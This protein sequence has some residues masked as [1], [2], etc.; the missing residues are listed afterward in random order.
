MTCTKEYNITKDHIFEL[1]RKIY[2]YMIDCCSYLIHNLGCQFMALTT[3]TT[4]TIFIVLIIPQKKSYNIE[5]N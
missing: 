3:T 2:V 5:R 1:R 4:T